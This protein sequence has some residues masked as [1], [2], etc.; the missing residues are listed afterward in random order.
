M[1]MSRADNSIKNWQ[2]LPIS[3]P[4]LDLHNINAHTV[5]QKYIDIYSSYPPETK[6]GACL[7]Q[8]LTKFAY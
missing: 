1:G 2:N 5:W 3:N 6:T 4:K 8:K 7:H